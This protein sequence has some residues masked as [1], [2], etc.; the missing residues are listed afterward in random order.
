MRPRGQSRS[1]S[2]RVPSS[3]RGRSYTRATR[4]SIDGVTRTFS[5]GA[6]RSATLGAP[7]LRTRWM[8][9]DKRR[10][11]RIDEASGLWRKNDPALADRFRRG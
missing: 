5:D 10:A 6:R 7:V 1:T 9:G 8:R 2:T 3:G 4:T 11:N